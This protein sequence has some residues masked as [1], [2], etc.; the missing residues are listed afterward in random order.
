MAETK[1]TIYK[2]L[3]NAK[4][5]IAWTKIEKLGEN[6]YN[7][8]KYFTPEQ[9]V[10]LVQEA[11]EQCWLVNT[12]SLKRNEY[13]E[14]WV[15]T[16]IDVDTWDKLEMECATTIPELKWA[17]STQM[18]GWCLTYTYRY[19]LS[20]A[21][22]IVSNADD[23][24]ESENMKRNTNG[25]VNKFTESVYKNFLK[26][27]D[28]YKSWDEAINAIKQKYVIDQVSEARVRALYEN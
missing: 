2:K 4:S 22:W 10:K 21:Y 24:D 20:I 25:W 12:F 28:T 7:H 18:L 13:W 27:K 5:L 15:L 26:S 17:V 1:T 11:N 14:Y 6:S 23:L 19:C 16:I 8:F 3:A 9:V